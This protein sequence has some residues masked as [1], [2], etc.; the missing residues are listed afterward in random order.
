MQMQKSKNLLLILG[1]EKVTLKIIPCSGEPQN[2]SRLFQFDTY[3]NYGNM[4]LLIIKLLTQ[5]RPTFF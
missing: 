1:L 5:L 4:Q 3:M 2:S